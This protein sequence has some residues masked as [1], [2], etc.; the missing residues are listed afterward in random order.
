[1]KLKFYKLYSIL[2]LL[3]LLSNSVFIKSDRD[4]LFYDETNYLAAGNESFAFLDSAIYKLHYK[5][6]S[7]FVKDPINRYFV[8]Y[9]L[10]LFMF[11]VS[12]LLVARSKKELILI[13]SFLVL[14][15][16]SRFASDLWPFI[17]LFSCVLLILLYSSFR[18]NY[19]FLSIF[20][21]FI[22]V[23]T[24][25]EFLYL[26]YLLFFLILYKTWKSEKNKYSLFI[27]Y[28][29]YLIGLTIILTHNPTDGERPYLA[30][31]QHYAFSKFVRNLYFADPWTTCDLLLTSDFGN[32]K[33]L[34]DLWALNP[35]HFGLHLIHNVGLFLNKIQDLFLLPPFVSIVL[36][37]LF[38]FVEGKDFLRILE[39]KNK[40]K[41]A[42]RLILYALLAVSFLTILVF[43]PREHYI[44]H[45]FVPAVLL[46]IQ[47]QK[48][49]Q[50]FRF[51]RTKPVPMYLMFTVLVAVFLSFYLQKAKSIRT[52]ALRSPC[53]NLFTLQVLQN[54]KLESYHILAFDGSVCAYLPNVPCK[55]FQI[56][57]KKLGFDVFL[58][59]NE[60]N[61]LILSEHWDRD[62]NYIE[63]PEYQFFI[64]HLFRTK[65]TG[66][67]YQ[68]NKFSLCP[69][70]KIL[71]KNQT[72]I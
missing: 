43:F 65:T 15:F 50:F 17:T 36:F 22:L 38:L 56:S 40:R 44:L 41:I 70:R 64:S 31:C 3:F 67:Q 66:D 8:N 4:I 68:Q 54:L 53:S 2:V 28:L 9:Q 48:L 59:Q 11:G 30:F 57:D 7:N 55:Q 60:I 23:Y 39:Q 69:S 14:L 1:M 46:L 52:S 45:F 49:N 37:L 62:P 47:N 26:Y 71:L 32:A 61:V 18:S 29:F 33:N 51:L 13:I 25:V 10:L 20:F 6:L 58:R 12:F 21:C 27:M 19:H 63:D 34:W 24:R 35:K 42:N 16:S 5:F 72:N